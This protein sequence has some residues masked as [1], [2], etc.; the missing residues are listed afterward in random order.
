MGQGWI[1]AMVGAATSVILS[2]VGSSMARYILLM[3]AIIAIP[4]I[5]NRSRTLISD[6]CIVGPTISRSLSLVVVLVSLRMVWIGK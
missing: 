1:A 3:S 2:D 6:G 4:C 5:R